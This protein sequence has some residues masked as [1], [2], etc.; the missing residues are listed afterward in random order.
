MAT[1]N[2]ISWLHVI[3]VRQDNFRW[4]IAWF[5]GWFFLFYNFYKCYTQFFLCSCSNLC[6][7]ITRS[8]IQINWDFHID[9]S[10]LPHGW[11]HFTSSHF[12]PCR[13]WIWFPRGSDSGKTLVPWSHSQTCYSSGGSCIAHPWR[14]PTSSPGQAEVGQTRPSLP[15]PR[16]TGIDGRCLPCNVQ[17]KAVFL[18]SNA[19]GNRPRCP[20]TCSL[21]RADLLL[22]P[23]LTRQVLP[24]HDSGESRT[25]VGE[26][27][28]ISGCCTQC[29]PCVCRWALS[30]HPWLWWR[31]LLKMDKRTDIRCRI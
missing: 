26:C 28:Q 12:Q 14:H 15:G 18:L 10:I 22:P 8:P 16:Y 2:S 1:I 19:T 20:P 23:K 5:F 27:P 31:H 9:H 11:F 29:A 13:I 7:A 3:I 6:E 4:L 24:F 30:F 25:I 21:W 17:T